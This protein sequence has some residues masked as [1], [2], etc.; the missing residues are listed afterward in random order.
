MRVTR[1][2]RGDGSAATLAAVAVAA[3]VTLAGC[4][5]R[6]GV[7]GT[8]VTR[9]NDKVGGDVVST[10]NGVGIRVADVTQVSNTLG[11]GPR[12]ATKRLQ[13]FLLLS[14]YAAS[15]PNLASAASPAEDRRRAVN[16][17]LADEE[18]A[19][20]PTEAVI[21]SAYD[22]HPERAHQPERRSFVAIVAASTVG[23][24]KAAVPAGADA[25]VPG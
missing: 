15:Q 9:G 21:K 3:L 24:A 1:S 23:V 2:T 10:V 7:G 17:W 8:T 13:D 18:R 4:T 25:G 6:S 16:A 22:A 5:A 12:E 20:L 19:H 14:Q 11:V